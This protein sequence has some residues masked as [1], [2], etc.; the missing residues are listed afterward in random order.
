[1]WVC[2]LKLAVALSL[3]LSVN[4]GKNKYEESID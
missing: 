1:M 2:I 3:A 4:A